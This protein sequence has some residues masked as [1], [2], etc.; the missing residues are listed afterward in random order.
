MDVEMERLQSL[1]VVVVGQHLLYGLTGVVG[2]RAG[3]ETHQGVIQVVAHHVL[4]AVVGEFCDCRHGD[5]H[6]VGHAGVGGEVLVDAS[7]RKVVAGHILVAQPRSHGP[8]ADLLGQRPGNHRHVLNLQRLMWISFQ[9][10]RHC[11]AEH[12][13]VGKCEPLGLQ[14][15][16]VFGGELY[17]V[18]ELHYTRN[19]LHLGHIAFKGRPYASRHTGIFLVLSVLFEAFSSDIEPFMLRIAGVV[20]LLEINL[21]H[22]QQSHGEPGGETH[23]LHHVAPH[24]CR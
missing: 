12:R 3:S 9:H 24:L 6:G 21:G 18:A 17:V 13:A 22:K 1:A 10:L 23:C 16:P 14:D 20:G 7:D 5:I 19:A 4:P 11:H 2:R 15:A 8:F